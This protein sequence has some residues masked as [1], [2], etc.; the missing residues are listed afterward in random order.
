M[1]SIKESAN[2]IK[3]SVLKKGQ[4]D[5]DIINKTTRNIELKLVDSIRGQKIKNSSLEKN[6]SKMSDILK[7]NLNIIFSNNTKALAGNLNDVFKNKDKE[8]IG[9]EYDKAESDTKIETLF[10][11]YQNEIKKQITLFLEKINISSAKA[12]EINIEIGNELNRIKN[13]SVGELIE[14]QE[15]INKNLISYISQQYEEYEKETLTKES[16]D[17]LIIEKNEQ[18]NNGEEKIPGLS[19][20]VRTDEELVEQVAEEEKKHIEEK[21]IDKNI[22]EI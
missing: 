11:N 19:D 5:R 22:E 20:Y 21:K 4:Y 9:K 1:A 12:N 8:S 13:K 10:D 15:K 6:I 18:E 2:N 14:Y 7:A 16:K 17:N 3:R